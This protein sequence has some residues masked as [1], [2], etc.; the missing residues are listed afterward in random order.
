[1]KDATTI[2][3]NDDSDEDGSDEP[4]LVKQR[5]CFWDN[6]DDNESIT[7]MTCHSSSPFLFL[8]KINII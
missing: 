2:F 1:M 3:L 7:S 6:V 5:N 4:I 8:K